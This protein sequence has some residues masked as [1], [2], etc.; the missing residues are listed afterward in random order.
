MDNPYAVEVLK[1]SLSFYNYYQLQNFSMKIS[2]SSIKGEISSSVVEGKAK[3]MVFNNNTQ[4]NKLQKLVTLVL[5][6]LN[7]DSLCE[8]RTFLN[9]S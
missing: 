8:L 1:F 7:S 3:K 9:D 2:S 6:K 5:S 4:K